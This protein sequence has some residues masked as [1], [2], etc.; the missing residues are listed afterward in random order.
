[1]TV[2]P[3]GAVLNQ[4]E[5]I[6]MCFTRFNRLCSQI[7]DAIMLI[8]QDQ[9]MPVNGS[10]NF[11]MVVNIDHRAVTF[12]KIQRRHRDRTIH[13]NRVDLFPGIIDQGIRYMKVLSYDFACVFRRGLC[14]GCC[15]HR[16]EEHH[17]ENNKME[18]SGGRA[19]RPAIRIS[20][21]R[22]RHSRRSFY[23]YAQYIEIIA[24]FLRSFRR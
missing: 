5:S 14:P 6:Q 2:I 16:Q 12:R 22:R 11:Q 7:G 15:L 1:M 10:L 24:V 23:G 18:D 19:H 17:Q 13:G 20:D 3:I 9:S 8:W 21:V 4:P